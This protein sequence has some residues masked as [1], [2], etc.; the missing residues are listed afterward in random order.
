MGGGVT[1]AAEGK[2]QDLCYDASDTDDYDEKLEICL[3][4]R[5][6]RVHRQQPTHHIHPDPF[7]PSYT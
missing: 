6:R 7:S 1:I 5:R 2:A 3:R 4:V